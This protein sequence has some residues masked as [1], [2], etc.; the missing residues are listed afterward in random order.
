[1]RRKADAIIQRLINKRI[2]IC[3]IYFRESGTDRL[4]KPKR[5]L[6]LSKDVEIAAMS[7][8]ARTNEKDMS[9]RD[10]MYDDY[11]YEEW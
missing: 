3:K 2:I 10:P 5:I 9:A 6:S 11:S 4:L 7:D 8:L 1:L